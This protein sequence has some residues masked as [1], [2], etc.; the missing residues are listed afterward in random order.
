LERESKTIRVEGN[1]KSEPYS[2]LGKILDDLARR[3]DVR[4]PYNIARHVMSV[5]S[6]EASGQAVSKYMYGKSLPKPAF[7]KAF[8]QTFELTPQEQVELA[9]VYAYGSHLRT[10]DRG[11]SISPS[12]IIRDL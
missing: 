2:Q 8:A 12:V 10:E 7:I 3:R 1:G 6:Y 4:G 9:W 11:L 5:S